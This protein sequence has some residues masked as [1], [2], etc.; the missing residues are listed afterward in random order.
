MASSGMVPDLTDSLPG[1]GVFCLGKGWTR[2]PGG[3]RRDGAWG[4]V[5]LHPPQ[6]FV[7]L[8]ALPLG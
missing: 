3:G 8:F 4:R 2:P 7:L 1:C 5:A 6:A